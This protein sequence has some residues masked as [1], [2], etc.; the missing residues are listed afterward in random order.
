MPTTDRVAGC[1]AGHRAAGV[2]QPA[3]EWH[4]SEGY[5]GG[6]FDTYVL[7]ANPQEADA[8]ISLEVLGD[9]ES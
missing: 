2:P 3:T 9:Q 6:P 5:I 7:V 8:T 1:A 4:L